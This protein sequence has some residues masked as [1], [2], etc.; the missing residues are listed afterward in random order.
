MGNKEKLCQANTLGRRAGVKGGAY[1]GNLSEG[2]VL[3]FSSPGWS[4]AL[5]S[6]GSTLRNGKKVRKNFFIK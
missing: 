2:K 1:R 6:T 3:A 4:A 5:L